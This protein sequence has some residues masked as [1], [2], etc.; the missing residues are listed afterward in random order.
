DALKG[1]VRRDKNVV[2]LRH[3]PHRA[4]G[5][6]AAFKSVRYVP[7]STGGEAVSWAARGE[8]EISA[9]N[10]RFPIQDGSKPFRAQQS[11]HLFPSLRRG[12][13]EVGGQNMDRLVGDMNPCPDGC[14]GFRPDS[15]GMRW[16]CG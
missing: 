8:I 9:Q 13:S 1:K 4:E 11:R 12:Q 6:D 14:A 10:D 16:E 7:Q 5:G 2:Q 15:S 3:Q